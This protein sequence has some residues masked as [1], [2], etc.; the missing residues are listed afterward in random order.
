MYQYPDFTEQQRKKI[1]EIQAVLTKIS[2]KQPVFFNITVYTNAGLI[3][4]HG[5]RKDNFPNWVLT[6]KGKQILNFVI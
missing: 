5:K 6:E 4:E 1:I 2:L 3:K